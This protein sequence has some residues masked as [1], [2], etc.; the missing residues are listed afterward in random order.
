MSDDQVEATSNIH[1]NAISSAGEGGDHDMS[2]FDTST[3]SEEQVLVSLT[4]SPRHVHFQLPNGD[5]EK[6]NRRSQ[7]TSE[8]PVKNGSQ[9]TYVAPLP[10]SSPLRRS[11]FPKDPLT[12]VTEYIDTVLRPRGGEC[13]D[14][15]A[16]GLSVLIQ[17]S[18]NRTS[19][20]ISIHRCLKFP[21][22][23]GRQPG[24]PDLNPFLIPKRNSG[25]S[26]AFPS[27]S[28]RPMFTNPSTD[29][30]AVLAASSD[31][32]RS[33]SVISPSTTSSPSRPSVSRTLSQNPNGTLYYQGGGSSRPRYRSSAFGSPTRKSVSFSRGFGE[34][35]SN[36]STPNGAAE[37]PSPSDGKRRRVGE[38]K[39]SSVAQASGSPAVTPNK[40]NT[41]PLATVSSTPALRFGTSSPASR[42]LA[43]TPARPSPLRQSIRA[44]SSSPGSS[45]PGSVNGGSPRSNS[46]GD[47]KSRTSETASEILAGI[48]KD[49]TPKKVRLLHIVPLTFPYICFYFGI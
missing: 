5:K 17:S 16:I 7:S 24:T 25:S 22:E 36:P 6:S 32:S 45:S 13:T 46:E 44:D 23:S 33:P 1:H 42:L 49:A 4:R 19:V 3:I 39:D 10:P 14:V 47:E 41:P 21:A 8:T 18:V 11:E 37:T 30:E 15:E 34:G 48:I 43:N 12:T 40:T 38:E 27:P 31:A 28:I 29:I 26:F 35:K 2:S 20:A 9:G